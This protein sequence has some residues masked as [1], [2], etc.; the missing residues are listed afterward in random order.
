MRGHRKESYQY[1]INA[2]G[3]EKIQGRT[4]LLIQTAK[5]FVKR[6]RIEEHIF[7]N[8]RCIEQ[9]VIDYFADIKRIKDFYG[10]D[11]VNSTKI[12][13]YTAYWVLKRKPL[14]MKVTIPEKVYQENPFLEDVIEW[15]TFY[16][17]VC[18][19]T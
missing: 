17:K 6:Y 12:A 15:Y 16:L 5:E 14:Q 18:F 4:S 13:A 8:T 11:K 19:S 2:F 10:I 3:E 1:L 9:I 7:V